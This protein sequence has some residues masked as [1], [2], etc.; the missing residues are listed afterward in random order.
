M[1]MLAVVGAGNMG[2][3][4]V[5][6]AVGNGVLRAAELLVIDPDQRRRDAMA[7][8]G[9]AVAERAS[10]APL[11]RSIMLAVKPQAFSGVAAEIGRLARPTVVISVMAGIESGSIRAALGG[12]SRVVRAMPNVACKVGA[13]MTALALGAGAAPGD[14]LLAMRLF[15]AIGATIRID[16]ALMHAAT[17]VGGSG[18]AYLFALAEAMERGAQEVGIPPVHVRRVVVQ[19]LLGALRLLAESGE[20]PAGL[21]EAVTSRGG[22]TEAALG[23]LVDRGFADSVV[24]AIAAARDR[25][26]ALARAPLEGAAALDRAGGGSGPQAN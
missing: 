14:E 26:A 3:A 5:A 24:A 17:A 18:P 8:L 19:T 21:R 22:T 2:A 7:A 23:V 15:D 13:G 9:C 1:P 20:T 4:I 16:E 11:A 6:G 25:G 12:E 10:S